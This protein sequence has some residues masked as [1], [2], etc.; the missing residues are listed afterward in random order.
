MTELSL[1]DFLHVLEGKRRELEAGRFNRDDILIEST[2]DQVDTMQQTVNRE[3]AIRTIDHRSN[4]L[5][6]VIAAI[7]RISEG[8]YGSCLCCEEEIPEKRLKA[9]PWAACCII[10][11]ELIDRTRPA[12]GA[13][14]EHFAGFEGYK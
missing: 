7:R 12:D 4:T 3:V 9:V 6:H 10:C 13:E 11:Q 14:V 2:A 5:K 1:D 8:T